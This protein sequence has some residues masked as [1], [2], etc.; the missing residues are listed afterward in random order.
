MSAIAIANAPPAVT[1]VEITEP[2]AVNAGIELLDQEAVQLQSMPLRARRVIVRLDAATVV[3]HSTNLRIR[4]RTSIVPGLVAYVA[5]GP[6]AKGSVNGLPIRSD[7]ILSAAAASEAEFVAEAGYQSMAFL[8]SEQDLRDHLAAR[9]RDAGFPFPRGIEPLQVDPERVRALFE[10]GK[11]LVDTAARKPRS[12]N[13]G[14]GERTAAQAE[15][16][17]ALLATLRDTGDYEHTRNDLTRQAHSVIVKKAE[18]YV[19]A[20]AGDHV[21]VSDLCRVAAAS[22]RTLENAFKEIMGLTPVSYLTRL[23]LHRVREGLLEATQGSTT[24][25]VEALKWGF[26]HFGEF[27]RAYKDCF[28][29]LP[30]DTLRKTPAKMQ[31]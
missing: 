19:L 24:V 16:L 27:S 11:R 8:I 10:W 5:F 29:E 9:E 26:W 14:S 3:F 4:T 28:G 17:E 23:R 30:S 13:D 7:M 20:R 12:F 25:S 15:L 21:D 31:P 6:R 1:V 22:E 2:T 18:D